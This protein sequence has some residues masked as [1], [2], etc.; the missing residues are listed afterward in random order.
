M[1]LQI[2]GGYASL[3][4]EGEEKLVCDKAKIL[5]KMIETTIK[6]CETYLNFKLV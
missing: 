1:K 3:I 4:D 6:E 2:L 5:L